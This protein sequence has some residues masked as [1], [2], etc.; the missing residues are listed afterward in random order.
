MY[1]AP[2]ILSADFTKLEEDIKRV[3][4]AKVLHIDVMDGVFVKNISFGPG[5]QGQIRKKFDMTFDT[6]L[7]I[8][9]PIKYIEEFYKQGSDM[10]TFHLE[11]DS[12]ID[13]TIDKIHSFGIKA[14][15]SIKPNTKVE[16]L[17]PYLNKIDLIL[18][19]SVE[20]GFGGQKFMPSALDKIEFLNSYRKEHNLNYLISVDGGINEETLPLVKKAGIDIA[21]MGSYIFKLSNPNEKILELEA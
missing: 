15:L 5:I 21:V 3:S 14:G 6:H 11:S 12:N 20:P 19:M 9:D 16:E 10:I 1:I 13:D 17:I 4:N 2:S 8:I 7:M 18:I